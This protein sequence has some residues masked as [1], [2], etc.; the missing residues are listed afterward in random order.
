M[1]IPDLYFYNIVIKQLSNYKCKE[2]SPEKDDFGLIFIFLNYKE[3]KWTGE[4]LYNEKIFNIKSSKIQITDCSNF[5]IPVNMQIDDN[6]N[7]TGMFYR[8]YNIG[9]IL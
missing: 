1:L 8:A 7:D 9:Y 2:L 3:N 5:Q 4:Y 6:W